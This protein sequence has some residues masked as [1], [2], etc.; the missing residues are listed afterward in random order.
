MMSEEVLVR[1][2]APHFCAGLVAKDGICIDA[3]PILRWT[4]GKTSKELAAYF[5]RKGWT[6]QRLSHREEV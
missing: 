6:W 1:V 2:E 5:A 4:V 3:A